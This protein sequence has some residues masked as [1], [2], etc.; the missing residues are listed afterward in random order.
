[1]EKCVTHTN[2]QFS[3]L[4]NSKEFLSLVLDNITSCV[5]L[6]DKEL[7]LRAFNNPLRT[8][9]SYRKDEDILY[10]RCGDVIGCMHQVEEQKTCGSTSKCKKCEIRVAVLHSYIDQIPICN[11]QITRNFYDSD[12]NKAEK[13]LQFST[14]LFSF[15]KEKYI[16]TIIDDITELKRL[17]ISNEKAEIKS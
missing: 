2:E 10:R 12:G 7:R 13:H 15:A 11:Q 5:M 6:L 16:I 1:M 14:R 9:F 4:S 3:V 8:I 17:Q